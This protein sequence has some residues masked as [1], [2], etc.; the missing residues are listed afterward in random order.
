MSNICYVKDYIKDYLL[1]K[2]FYI[3]FNLK[4]NHN[5]SGLIENFKYTCLKQLYKN[6]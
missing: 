6:A 4:S 3:I 5:Q 2:L 1:R